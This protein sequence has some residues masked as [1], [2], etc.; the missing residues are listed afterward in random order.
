MHSLSV[1]RWSEEFRRLLGFEQGDEIGFPNLVTSWSD[2]LHPDDAQATFQAFGAC[3][4]DRSSRTGYDVIYRLQMKNGEYRWFR[5]VGGVGRNAQGVAVRACG[6]LIDVHNERSQ[7][8][9]ATLFEGSSGVGLWDALFH[10]GDPMHAKSQ[11]KWSKEFR[12]LLGFAADDTRGFPDVVTSWSDRLHPDDAQATF[13]AF[14]ACLNDRTNR[15]GYDVM[16]RLKMKD[17]G[18]RWF[19]AIGGV[20]RDSQGVAL[21]AC[22]SLIDV[23]AQKQAE[24]RQ[25]EAEK[26]WRDSITNLA[27]SLDDSVATAANRASANARTVAAATE[28]L[29]GSITEISSRAAQAADSSSRAA[30]AAERTDLGVQALVNAAERIG[31]I[32]EL[33]GAIAAQTNLLALN[34]TIEAARAG[35][36]GKGF[37]VVASEVKSLANQSASASGQIAAQITSVQNEARQAVEAIRGIGA[38]IRDVREVSS[39]IAAAVA[40]QDSAAKEIAERVS[41]VVQD[42]EGVSANTASATARMKQSD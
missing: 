39:T 36:A 4:N 19:R 10:N 21:R 30:E 25:K 1:W 7:L 35:T 18:Y 5:A 34:A 27:N 37:A 41:R 9:R 14:G 16:Y 38:M 31:A 3:L 17:G 6:S 23:D 12:R 26:E 2:R 42:V 32:T 15:T 24:L 28:H 8:E 22:G 20:T 13:Q 11:W 33:I 29:A 40:Q